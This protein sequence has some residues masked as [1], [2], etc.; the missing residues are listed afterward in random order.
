[1][2]TKGLITHE[3]LHDVGLR[4]RGLAKVSGIETQAGLTLIPQQL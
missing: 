2:K 4:D 1:M 3:A